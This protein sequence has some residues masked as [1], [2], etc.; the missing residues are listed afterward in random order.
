[1]E[2][3]WHGLAPGSVSLVMSELSMTWEYF[4]KGRAAD[5]FQI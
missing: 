5:I 1:M 4:W 3:E 2:A